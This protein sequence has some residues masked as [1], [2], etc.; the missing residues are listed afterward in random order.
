MTNHTF[1]NFFYCHIFSSCREQQF[2]HCVIRLLTDQRQK[3]YYSAGQK[4]W[5]PKFS[6]HLIASHAFCFHRTVTSHVSIDSSFSQ[7][8]N[9]LSFIFVDAHGRSRGQ[10]KEKSHFSEIINFKYAKMK[11]RK[12][13]RNSLFGLTVAVSTSQHDMTQYTERERKNCHGQIL[14]KESL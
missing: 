1:L 2:F 10:V 6:L 3:K 9:A 12:K 13:E 8:A 11:E 4:N 7:L 5:P 14:I